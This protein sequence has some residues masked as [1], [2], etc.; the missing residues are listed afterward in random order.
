MR[1]WWFKVICGLALAGCIADSDDAPAM[2]AD[3]AAQA[4]DMAGSTPDMSGPDPTMDA[5]LATDRGVPAPDMGPGTPEDGAVDPPAV[6]AAVPDAASPPEEA[7]A[8]CATCGEYAETCAEICAA[9]RGALEPAPAAAWWDCVAEDPC[10]Q[11]RAW[12]CFDG[13]GCNDEVLVAAHC[14]ALARCAVNGRGSLDE[15]ACRADPYREPQLWSCLPPERREGLAA[16]LGG[17]ACDE[18]EMCLSNAAC[19]GAVGCTRVMTTRL[20]LDCHR[21]CFGPG[22]SCGQGQDR[23]GRCMGHCGEAAHRLGD[24]HRRELEACALSEEMCVGLPSTRVSFCAGRLQCD[25]ARLADGVA[26]AAARCGPQP[27]AAA[28][29]HRWS[30]LGEVLV[31]AAERCLAEAPCAELGACLQTAACGERAGCLDF[32]AELTAADP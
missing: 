1:F 13:L 8:V 4:L 14:D 16:C 17:M 28:E 3:A 31:E 10:A 15:A 30:C 9:I 12:T 19:A 11:E 25:T 24:A 26:A 2:S 27:E 29:V 7:C 6:D 18:L 22:Y 23:Y 21:I 5:Q 32:L 20:V